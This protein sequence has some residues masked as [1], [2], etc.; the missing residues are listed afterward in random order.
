MDRRVALGV[1]LL[2][3][4]PAT[5]AANAG[6]AASP[7]LDTVRTDNAGVAT[8]IGRGFGGACSQCDVIADYGGFRYALTVHHW[9][10]DRIVAHLPDIN[11][12]SQAT[13]QV[14][15]P[16]GKTNTQRVSIP[17][18]IVPSAD[19]QHPV[20]PPPPDLL[21]FNKRSDRKVGAKGDERID[22]STQ[23]PACG[24]EALLFDHAR[25]VFGKRRFGD[26]QFVATPKPGCTR[27]DPL[28]V[29]WYHEPTGYL[30]FQV[31]VYRRRVEG[32]CPAR[33]R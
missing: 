32:I 25:I 30:D 15:T 9:S 1:W 26:A 18:R 24:Q 27:C 13:L 31:H 3:A 21:S 5:W 16:N 19:L 10:E 17:R 28:L 7:I 14:V 6:R 23:S 29:R 33:K 4:S 20:Q 8:L 12:T 2:I 22:V 11:L